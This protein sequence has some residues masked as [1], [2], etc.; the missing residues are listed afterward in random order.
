MKK[1]V[2]SRSTRA[3]RVRRMRPV[4]ATG[5]LALGLVCAAAF[6]GITV[7]ANALERAK[8]VLA[9]EIAA[10][11]ARNAQ[12]DAAIAQKST[13]DY[14]I[15]KAQDYDFVKKGEGLIAVERSAPTTSAAHVDAE[16]A[17]RVA[18]WIRLF[19]GTR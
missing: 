18:R 15:Q 3:K 8:G 11:Q 5:V 19:F 4:I 14:L 12:L 13:T 9:D 16:R 6:T 7:Q 17:S 2:R 1:Q 10:E